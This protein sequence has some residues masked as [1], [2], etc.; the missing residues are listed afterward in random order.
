VSSVSGYLFSGKES[1]NFNVGKIGEDQ[2]CDY[3]KRKG[4]TRDEA[5]IWLAPNL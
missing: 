2:L 5:A 4:M 3:A 1:V